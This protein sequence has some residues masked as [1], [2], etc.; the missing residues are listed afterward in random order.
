VSR[1]KARRRIRAHVDDGGDHKYSD[2]LRAAQLRRASLVAR[3]KLI[4]FTKITMPSPKDP[5]DVTVS[6]F[7]DAVHHRLIAEKL[8]AVERGDITRLIITMPPRHGKSE[9]ASR[10]FPAWFMGRHPMWEVI[11]ATYNQTFAED[12][13]GEVRDIMNS[14]QY[15]LVFPDAQLKRD[16]QARDKLSME[17]INGIKSGALYF[18]GADGSVTGRG[19]HLFLIDDPFKNREMAESETNRRKVW[20]FFTSTAYTRLAP[21][22]RIVIILTRWHEDDLVG[23]LF[24]PAFVDPEISKDYEILSLPG[25]AEDDDPL[26]RKP[27]E[28]LWPERYPAD[29][30]DVTRRV[31]GPRDW[32]SLYQQRPTVQDGDFFTKGMFKPYTRDD[33][34]DDFRGIFRIYGASDHAV[35][36]NQ[37]NDKSVLGCVGFDSHGDI[38]ILPDVRWEKMDGEAQVDEM[39]AQMLRH[40]PVTWWAEKGHISSAIGP[41]LRR[42][43]FE[44]KVPTWLQEKT[45]SA[46]KEKR[47]QSIRARAALRPI[48]VPAFMEWWEKA[49]AE[50][51]AF[52]NG[53]HDDFVDWLAWIGLGLETEFSATPV[54]RN[55]KPSGPEVGSGA[56]VVWRSKKDKERQAAA[57]KRRGW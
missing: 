2:A 34:P 11:F 15:G 47:A 23:R 55:E 5:T 53:R 1:D 19:A 37:K 40:R 43:M 33:L 14:P 36:K 51:L 10:R 9:L 57:N 18:A 38:W 56:W 4:D 31:I 13:G 21:G 32:A 22:G 24:D 35:G 8:E 20:E 7:E 44:R 6:R 54:A 3:D 30:L 12:F 26:G 41:Y 48:R 45:P 42:Q 49:E 25:L 50:L 16:S 46:D 17:D 29:V 27:G 52:P 39:I 28:A